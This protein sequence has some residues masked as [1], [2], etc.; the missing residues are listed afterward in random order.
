MT[1]QEILYKLIQGMD[2]YLC[3]GVPL[4]IWEVV[5]NLTEELYGPAGLE[6][7][8]LAHTLNGSYEPPLHYIQAWEDGGN[9]EV[10]PSVVID[11]LNAL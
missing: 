3:L 11:R 8:S 2:P 6:I 7:V 4:S 5:A 9:F 10:I 1:K